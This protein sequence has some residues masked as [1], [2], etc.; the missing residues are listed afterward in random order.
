MHIGFIIGGAVAAGGIIAL[1]LKGANGASS[2]P[3]EVVSGLTAEQV[4]EFFKAPEILEKLKADK[5][6]L[7]VAVK[8][9][10]KS[11]RIHVC[12]TLFDKEKNEVNEYVKIFSTRNI[13]E[14]LQDMF[15]DKDM[16]V[17]Q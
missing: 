14:D 3:K 10:K 9:I 7:A 11:G 15:G 8:E 16:I 2:I 12:C 5:N 6:L 13:S 4:V 17:L 1:I